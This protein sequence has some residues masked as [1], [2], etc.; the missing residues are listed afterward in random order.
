LQ[1]SKISK[2]GPLGGSFLPEWFLTLVSPVRSCEVEL[3]VLW[4]RNSVCICTLAQSHNFKCLWYWFPTLTPHKC[5]AVLSRYRFQEISALVLSAVTGQ[6]KRE[7]PPNCGAL[8]FTSRRQLVFQFIIDVNGLRNS[9]ATDALEVQKG[10]LKTE[11]RKNISTSW[12][13]LQASASHPWLLWQHYACF[14]IFKSQNILTLI[15]ISYNP[16]LREIEEANRRVQGMYRSWSLGWPV[17]NKPSQVYLMHESIR[18]WE[19]P[20]VRRC[21][22]HQFVLAKQEFHSLTSWLWISCTVYNRTWWN[23]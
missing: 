12:F 16:T 15:C 23:E 18:N 22:N 1:V 20:V 6:Q 9:I 10:A 19:F 14:S 13:S 5:S 4:T 3:F 2:W 21:V 7:P 17:I 8:C 11:H